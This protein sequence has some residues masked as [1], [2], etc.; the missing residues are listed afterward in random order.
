MKD[1]EANL[2]YH[3]KNKEL[4]LEAIHHSSLKKFAVQFERL[5]FLGDRV[6]GL[7]IAEYIFRNFAGA[8]GVMAK[9]HAAL[10]CADSCRIVADKLGISD[11]IETAGEQLKTNKTVLADSMEA[12]LGAI[13]ID[14]DYETVKQT[15]LCLWKPVFENYDESQQDPKTRLQEICQSSSGK[16]PL[17]KVISVSGPDHAPVFKI[18][19]SALGN[20]IE[21]TGSSK[22]DAETK[23]ARLMLKKLQGN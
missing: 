13:F 15:I 5:E 23:A 18:S 12:I 8:E 7:V 16:T 19:L 14:S 22:K 3:F 4:L 20:K 11:I 1:I 17:Y 6:L 10:V 9:R 2:K 21:T